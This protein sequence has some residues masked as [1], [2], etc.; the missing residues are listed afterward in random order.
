MRVR[1]SAVEVIAGVIGNHRYDISD[2]HVHRCVCGL[3]IGRESDALDNHRAI[4]VD[5]ALGGL[6]RDFD[7]EVLMMHGSPRP[8][9]CDVVSRWVSRWMAEEAI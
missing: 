8:V 4:E 3:D 9:R 7:Y 2:V 1:D 6:E 5:R